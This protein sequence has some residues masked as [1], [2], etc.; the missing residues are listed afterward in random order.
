MNEDDSFDETARFESLNPCRTLKD[1]L[2]KAL[3]VSRLPR[4]ERRSL[5]PGH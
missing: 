4:L 2:K 5:S 3:E 1:T